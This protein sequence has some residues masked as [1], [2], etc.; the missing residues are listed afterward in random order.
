MKI[1]FYV[2]FKGM[3]CVYK[4]NILSFYFETDI[5]QK[6]TF[7]FPN[8]KEIMPYSRQFVPEL[9]SRSRPITPLYPDPISKYN[10]VSS[11]FVSYKT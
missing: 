9:G 11:W 10:E 4:N 7:C 6:C 1:S 5:E 3:S 2:I 8:S